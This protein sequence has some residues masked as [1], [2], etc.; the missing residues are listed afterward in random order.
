MMRG[1][2]YHASFVNDLI[3]NHFRKT[4]PSALI[5][6]DRIRIFVL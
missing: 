3:F 6:S 5:N 2:I 1:R 4:P